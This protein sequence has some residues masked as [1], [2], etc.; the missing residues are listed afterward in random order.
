[1]ADFISKRS[2]TALGGGQTQ[3]GGDVFDKKGYLVKRIRAN[4]VNCDDVNPSLEEITTFT[5]GAIGDA[6]RE[7]ASVAQDSTLS[8]EDFKVG[9]NVEVTEGG[10][11]NLLGTVQSVEGGI[12]TIKPQGAFGLEVSYIC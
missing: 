4:L 11:A 12:V 1:M 9:E 5:G 3:F 2:L 10:L 7:L 6:E 8:P